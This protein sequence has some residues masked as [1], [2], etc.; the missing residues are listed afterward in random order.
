MSSQCVLAAL[1]EHYGAM[2]LRCSYA[3]PWTFTRPNV[4]SGRMLDPAQVLFAM[5]LQQHAVIGKTTVKR[6]ASIY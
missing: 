1:G 5:A 6:S 4:M 2:R 3:Q